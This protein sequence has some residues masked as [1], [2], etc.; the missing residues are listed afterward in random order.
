MLKINLGLRELDLSHTQLGNTG[1]GRA[2]GQPPRKLSVDKRW[3]KL[4]ANIITG[5]SKSGGH[6]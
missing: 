2:W 3:L 4:V 1:A 5:R 6:K